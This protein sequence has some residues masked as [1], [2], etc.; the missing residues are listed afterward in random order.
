MFTL[1]DGYTSDFE[2]LLTKANCMLL[3]I[4]ALSEVRGTLIDIQLYALEIKIPCI[5]VHFQLLEIPEYLYR[6][7][8]STRKSNPEFNHVLFNPVE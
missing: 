8:F 6:V 3:P 2:S 1:S 5:R 7:V 4:T